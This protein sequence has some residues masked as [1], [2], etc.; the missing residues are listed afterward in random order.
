M[1]DGP[2]L[3]KNLSYLSSL[4]DESWHLADADMTVASHNALIFNPIAGVH[5]LPK[6]RFLLMAL[7][8]FTLPFNE[9][10][11]MAYADARRSIGSRI[12]ARDRSRRRGTF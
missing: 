12:I 2:R 4:V 11:A 8:S 5:I 10:I 7:C 1:A 3:H 6:P 9:H